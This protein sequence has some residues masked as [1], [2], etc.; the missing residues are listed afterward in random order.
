MSSS[1]VR[2]ELIRSAKSVVVKIGTSVITKPDGRLDNRR[3]RR[4]ADQVAELRERGLKITVVSSGA[5]G[6]GMGVLGMATRPTT[7]PTMQAV[8]AVG[9]RAL[10]RLFEDAFSRHGL[11]A[12]QILVTRGDFEN[13]TRYLNIR[14]TID[15]IHRISAIPIIN[16][17][18]TVSVDEIR[19][20]DN[21]IIA[22][23]TTNMLKAGLL[24]LLTVVD[25]LL[26]REGKLIDVVHRIDD[27]VMA[28]VGRS[29]SRLG[30]GG[31]QSK[32]QAVQ[33]VTDS[34]EVAV[35]ASGL[36]PKC[37]IRLIDGKKLGTVFVPAA[38]K[39]SSR[40]RWIGFSVRPAGR[41][42]VDAGA[43]K[44]IRSGGKSLLPIG[45]TAIEGSF[46]RGDVV[47][48]VGPTGSVFA[49]GLVNFSSKR[50]D[51]IKGL[52]S[53]QLK[54]ALGKNPP[55]DEVVHRDQLAL[56]NHRRNV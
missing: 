1:Q 19:F 24:A 5:I 6:A 51:A 13:R 26:D 11:H 8:A 34:G 28:L 12:A 43:A 37:L 15:T 46:V 7:L 30:S 20:G 53:S 48:I 36:K 21:D 10:M 54:N 50:V 4:L 9:Q 32:L 16:E 27:Q 52:R 25:G 22:A 39:M 35:I 18:D 31:M 49:R 14:N 2:K 45:I 38:T 33:M 41:I 17:N 23:Q 55:F 56:V 42:A 29:K 47:E 44:A 40:Q 3:I